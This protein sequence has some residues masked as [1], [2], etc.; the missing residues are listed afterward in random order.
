MLNVP[1]GVAGVPAQ[2]QAVF[3]RGALAHVAAGPASE[4]ADFSLL[5]DA[6]H[7]LLANLV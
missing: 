4:I 3:A 1:V 6:G 7:E 2:V 5:A